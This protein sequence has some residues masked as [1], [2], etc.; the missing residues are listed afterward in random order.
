M[1]HFDVRAL[2]AGELREA[3]AVYRRALHFPP[4]GNEEWEA[5]R[6]DF[7][8]ERY[9]GVVEDG[10][11]VGTLYTYSSSMA[12]PGGN[13]VPMGGTSRGSVRADRTRRGIMN[14]LMRFQLEDAKRRG[15]LLA[16]CRP[17]EAMLYGRVGYGVSAYAREV[18]LRGARVLPEVPFVG[19]VRLVGIDEAKKVL[20][21]LYERI[22]L[23]RPGMI[24]RGPDLWAMIWRSVRYGYRF[25]VR[26]GPDGDD[27]FAVLRTGRMVNEE[28]EDHRGRLTI[29]EL[30]GASAAAVNDLWQFVL[31]IDLVGEV[32]AE[33]RPVDEQPELLLVDPRRCRTGKLADHVWVRLVDVLAALAARSYGDAEPVVVAVEDRF[34]PENSGTYEISSAGVSRVSRAADL[35]LRVDVLSM[36]YL[37]AVRPSALAA[38]GRIRVHDVKSVAAADRLF[39]TD[40]VAWCGTEF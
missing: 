17:S 32:V 22:G 7:V 13:V 23:H 26:S 6:D 2:D 12:V 39:A 14:A 28:N 10:A 18:S 21:A 1:A 37:G 31:G 33:H 35:E 30:H 40:E 8:P 9:L 24:G 34:V 19:Q 25:L 29:T 5:T 11:V 20:P 15:E 38:A 3:T 36:I 4:P 16:S 27:G